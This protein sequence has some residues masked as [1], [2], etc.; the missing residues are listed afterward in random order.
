MTRAAAKVVVSAPPER[1][2]AETAYDKLKAS[3]FDFELL[4][5]DRFS[6]TEIAER[7][8]MSRTPVRDALYRLEREGYLQV[9]LRIGWSVRPFDFRQFEN[10]Y[11]LRLILEEASVTRLCDLPERVGLEALKVAWLV[12]A[13]ERLTLPKAVAALDEAFHTALVEAA[14]NPEVA[15]CHRE[16]TERIRIIRRLDFTQG[17]RIDR[18]Y[19]EHG[20]ILGAVIRR[21]ADEANRLL[22]SHIEASKAEVRK[23]TLH[24]LYTARSTSAEP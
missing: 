18:T 8:S 9:H 1:S 3:I 5:G 22:R 10:Y 15:R 23:I 2:L 19:E 7:L 20:Q 14:G 21:R 12:P 6:E 17:H 24:R 16:V 11:D 4:P 13:A